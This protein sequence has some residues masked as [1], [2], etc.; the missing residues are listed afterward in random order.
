MKTSPMA[1]GK[2]GKCTRIFSSWPESICDWR[3]WAFAI[4]AFVIVPG[5]V[6]AQPKPDFTT[7]GMR[8][9][10]SSGDK[11]IEGTLISRGLLG[12]NL[13]RNSVTI[14]PPTG[15]EVDET[16]QRAKQDGATI[17][18]TRTWTEELNQ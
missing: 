16:V 2:P 5:V 1:L 6:L 13:A 18:Q 3:T 7:G 9:A 17:S 15:M 11:S 4:A 12:S 10:P 14:I 8:A